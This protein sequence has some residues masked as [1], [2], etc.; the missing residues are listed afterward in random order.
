MT[1]EQSN[2]IITFVADGV[3]TIFTL[4]FEVESKDNLKVSINRVNRFQE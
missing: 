4:T 3:T 1:V 2:P